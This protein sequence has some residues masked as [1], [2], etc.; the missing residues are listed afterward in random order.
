M[1][2][3][4]SL[5]SSDWLQDLVTCQ[6]ITTMLTLKLRR[7]FSNLLVS[8]RDNWYIKR[9]LLNERVKQLHIDEETSVRCKVWK[10]YE[11]SKWQHQSQN[12]I[13]KVNIQVQKMKNSNFDLWI[14]WLLCSKKQDHQSRNSTKYHDKCNR[15]FQNYISNLSSKHTEKSSTQFWVFSTYFYFKSV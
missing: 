10:R 11:Q 8:D 4:E 3:T 12:F 13:H 2:V 14:F 5:L 9:E 7:E 1:L 15:D 6:F